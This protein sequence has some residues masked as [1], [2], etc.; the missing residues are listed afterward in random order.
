M[1]SNESIDIYS[2][3]EPQLAFHHRITFRLNLHYQSVKAM[4]YPLKSYG[5]KLESAEE[6][7]ERGQQDLEL[8]KEMTEED[9][10]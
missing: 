10:D 3:R 9:N 6:R 7:I 4:R 5:K 1:S 8:A 2:T